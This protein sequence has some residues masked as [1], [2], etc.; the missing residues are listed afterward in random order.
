MDKRKF[1]VIRI[2]IGTLFGKKH[3]CVSVALEINL[4][5]RQ[6]YRKNGEEAD[7]RNDKAIKFLKVM[8]MAAILKQ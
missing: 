6:E 1:N 5:R 3:Y 8:R 2:T 4:V 7:G